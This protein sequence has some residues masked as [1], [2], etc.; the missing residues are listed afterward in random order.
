[1]KSIKYYYFMMF[2]LTGISLILAMLFVDYVN[3]AFYNYDMC[4]KKYMDEQGHPN[5]YDQSNSHELI[6]ACYDFK[7][8]FLNPI[9]QFV[10]LYPLTILVMRFLVLGSR[11]EFISLNGQDIHSRFYKDR[12]SRSPIT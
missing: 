12:N 4:G 1:M 8:I 6:N 7:N 10:T 2:V 5:I 9:I 3:P 11:P